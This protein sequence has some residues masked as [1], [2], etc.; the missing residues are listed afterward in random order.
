M[1]D[2]A[3]GALISMAVWMVVINVLERK[4]SDEEKAAEI[5]TNLYLLVGWFLGVYI[6]EAVL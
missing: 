4:V 5:Y 6:L 3:V 1:V 2:F